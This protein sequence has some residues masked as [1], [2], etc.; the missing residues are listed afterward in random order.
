ML[1]SDV[2]RALSCHVLSESLCATC[3]SA[4]PWHSLAYLGSVQKTLLEGHHPVKHQCLCTMWESTSASQAKG[5]KTARNFQCKQSILF[6]M[7][8]PGKKLSSSG[9]SIYIFPSSIVMP[10]RAETDCI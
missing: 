5:Q 8:F 10:E 6:L 9:K 2:W 4:S 1:D 7:I 3:A